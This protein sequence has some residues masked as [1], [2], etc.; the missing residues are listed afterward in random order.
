MPNKFKKP[1]RFILLGIL[2]LSAS[3]F[4]QTP[5]LMP[6]PQQQFFTNTGAVCSGCFLYTY[7][8]GTNTP[9]A[10]FTDYT[11]ST[12]NTNPIILN[13]SGYPQTAIGTLVGVWLQQGLSY[14]I[15]LQNTAHVQLWL[16][17]GIT[18]AN[19]GSTVTIT[20]PSCNQ[21]EIGATNTQTG[22]CFPAPL[23][24]ITLTFPSA[25]DVLVG[26][27]TQDTL[28][29]KTL[30]SPSFTGT[31]NSSGTAVPG[32]GFISRTVNP[33][34]FTTTSTTLTP[35]MT[36][37]AMAPNTTYSFQCHIFSDSSASTTSIFFG[38][39]GPASPSQIRIMGELLI[40]DPTGKGSAYLASYSNMGSGGNATAGVHEFSHFNGTVT[41]GP[42]AGNLTISIGNGDNSSTIT[43]ELNSFCIAF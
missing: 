5:L 9:Q 21:F 26:R 37:A 16:I 28:T 39:A 7:V 43:V 25:S 1:L 41:N 2:A 17:D 35:F 15:V 32:G 29:N 42:N 12:A 13:S 36:I 11:G 31:L 10:T 22:L 8:S 3:A 38:F 40:N 20:Q 14:R 6:T 23:A 4:A 33:S 34:N 27:N 30:A 18:G 24:N 19:F